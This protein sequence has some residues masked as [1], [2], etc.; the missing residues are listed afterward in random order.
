VRNA[1]EG[2]DIAAIKTAS[3][4]LT[5]VSHRLAEEMY[6]KAGTAAGGGTAGGGPSQE[7]PGESPPGSGPTMDAEFREEEK[8]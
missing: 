4:E 7:S 2:N 8:K 3:D 1:L 6:K 5:K